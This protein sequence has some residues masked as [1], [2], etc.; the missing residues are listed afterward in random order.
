MKKSKFNNL[1]RPE[2]NRKKEQDDRPFDS[3]LEEYKKL[4]RMNQTRE[5]QEQ[6]EK[7]RKD[8]LRSIIPKQKNNQ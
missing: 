4:E 8:F 5:V 3:N 2:R 7:I 1:D 6:M